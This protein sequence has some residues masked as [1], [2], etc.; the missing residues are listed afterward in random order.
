MINGKIVFELMDSRGLPLEIIRERLREKGLCFN[1]IEFIEAAIASKNYSYPKIK[2][3]LMLDLPEGKEKK[4]LSI[5]L[6]GYWEK[7]EYFQE[8]YDIGKYN[9]A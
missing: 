1:V 7:R 2:S 4:L 9:S 3:R 6:D 8:K 5:I